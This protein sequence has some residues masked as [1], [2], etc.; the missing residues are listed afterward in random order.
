MAS[1]AARTSVPAIKVT[2][3]LVQPKQV[4]LARPVSRALT[5]R[6]A[7][8]ASRQL[9]TTVYA[10]REVVSSDN[11]PAALG[12]YSQAIKANGTVYVSGC[13][14]LIPETMKFVD[15]TIEGQ[16]EQCMKNM[17]AVLEAAGCTHADV[18]KTTV[19]LADIGD[20]ANANAI[21]AK[22]F[23][24]SPPARSCFAVKTL[25]LNALIEIEAIA[26]PK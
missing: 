22:Y 19:L 11:A 13:L 5:S 26:V 14:G 24:E 21:Y 3:S 20:F 6:P 7:R 4:S 23:P 17:G 16:T 8:V 25:P 12:P 15:D 1:I 2:R 18:V 10:S 9:S